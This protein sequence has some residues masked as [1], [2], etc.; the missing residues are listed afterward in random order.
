MRQY[1]SKTQTRMQESANRR[2]ESSVQT[3]KAQKIFT[4][5]WSDVDKPDVWTLEMFQYR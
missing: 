2:L 5:A 3:S 4:A 1:D